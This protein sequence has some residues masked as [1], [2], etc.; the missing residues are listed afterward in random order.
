MTC[1][2]GTP[3]PEEWALRLAVLFTMLDEIREAYG[4][5]LAVVSGYRTATYNKKVGGA[6]ESRHQNGEAADIRP[7]GKHSPGDVDRLHEIIIAMVAKRKLKQI[8]GVGRYTRWVHVDIR[9]RK[10]NGN[11]ARWDGRK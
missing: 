2:D 6:K 11:I 3:Y 4:A 1:K 5:A 8:G 10:P 9:A 7:A